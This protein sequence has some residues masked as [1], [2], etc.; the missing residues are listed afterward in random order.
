LIL[1]SIDQH[2]SYKD[3]KRMAPYLP[4]L[5]LS[6]TSATGAGIASTGATASAPSFST[7]NLAAELSGR[8]YSVESIGKILGGNMMRALRSVLRSIHFPRSYGPR[9][10]VNRDEGEKGRAF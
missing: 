5:P 6:L 7:G 2:P 1:R 3:T 10:F 9:L 4:S 8:N